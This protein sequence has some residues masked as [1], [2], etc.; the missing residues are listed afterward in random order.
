M[1]VDSQVEILPALDVVFGHALDRGN[2]EGNVDPVNGQE[3]GLV[4][5]IDNDLVRFQVRREFIDGS[6]GLDFFESLSA[7]PFAL[8]L[9]RRFGLVSFCLFSQDFL[10][11][12][13]RE[14]RVRVN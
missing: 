7:D 6:I 10:M 14:G 4:H 12:I 2:V 5:L 1:E 3:N 9:C 8:G 13:I 11:K